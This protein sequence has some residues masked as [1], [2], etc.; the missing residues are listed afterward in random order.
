M[1]SVGAG[2]EY[3]SSVVQGVQLNHSSSDDA[4]HRKEHRKMTESLK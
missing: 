4:D 2:V 1:Y 3:F